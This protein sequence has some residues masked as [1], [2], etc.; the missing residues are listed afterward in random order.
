MP[1]IAPAEVQIVREIEFKP[2]ISTILGNITMSEVPTYCLVLPLAGGDHY[3]ESPRATC[4]L[5][6]ANRGAAD[7]PIEITPSILRSE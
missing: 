6:G 7:S 3:L 4:A 1:Q 5:R 2:A